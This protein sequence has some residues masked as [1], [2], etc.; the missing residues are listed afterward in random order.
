LDESSLETYDP[1]FKMN[2][3]LREKEEVEAIKKHL[4]AG[5]IDAISTDHAPHLLLDKDLEFE[6]CANG[7]VGLET[8][9]G[10][11]ITHLVKEKFI[12]F[13]RLVELMSLNPARILSLNNK[14]SLKPGSDADITIIDPLEKWVV[15]KHKFKSK[16]RNTPFH[17]NKLVGKAKKVLV[18][19]GEI[20]L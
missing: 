3:P 2:P 15:D 14:G 8:S 12:D 5:S 10:L 16:G 6:N 7:I 4:K 1:K 13:S 9:L 11:V 20:N 18:S 19:G 17:G